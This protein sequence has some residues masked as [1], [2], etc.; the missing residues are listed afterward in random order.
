MIGRGPRDTIIANPS[1]SLHFRCMAWTNPFSEE[2]RDPFYVPSR[3]GERIRFFASV[4]FLAF[5]LLG[6]W[7]VP[8]SGGNGAILA[9]SILAAIASFA[10]GL[11]LRRHRQAKSLEV[12]DQLA[13]HFDKVQ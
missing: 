1:A 12:A 10:Q 9:I 5:F 11:S 8:L 2:S 3:T 6:L 7:R 13:S 4:T